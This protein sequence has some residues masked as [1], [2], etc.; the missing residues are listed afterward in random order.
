MSFPCLHNEKIVQ[1][2]G[3]INNTD[4]MKY[5]YSCLL[6]QFCCFHCCAYCIIQTCTIEATSY[7]DIQ[8]P[9]YS[10]ARVHWNVK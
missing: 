2:T 1:F 10:S 5:G 3:H 6:Y 9:Q 8:F 7:Q 4:S